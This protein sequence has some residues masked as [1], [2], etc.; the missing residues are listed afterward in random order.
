MRISNLDRVHQLIYIFSHSSPSLRKYKWHPGI[1]P[2]KMLQ[3][4]FVRLW[5]YSWFMKYCHPKLASAGITVVDVGRCQQ[6]FLAPLLGKAQSEIYRQSCEQN[7]N[8]YSLAKQANLALFSCL[9]WY[10]NRVVYDRFR[11]AAKLLF[12]SR[13][14]FEEDASSSRITSEIT[15]GSRISHRI[16]VSFSS[17]GPEDTLWL[18]CSVC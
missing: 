4:Y 9:R 3:R 11:L 5:I 7:R 2:G 17:Y 8:W 13:V 1:L 6:A 18:L 10:E 16:I 15:L 14:T 12:R